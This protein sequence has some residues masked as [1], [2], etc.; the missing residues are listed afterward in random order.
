[1]AENRGRTE[2]S[3]FGV[4]QLRQLP[5]DLRQAVKRDARIQMMYVVIANISGEPGH[6]AVRFQEAGR[7]Q[8]RLFISPAGFVAIRNLGKVVLSVE[9]V[10][11]NG[12]SDEV[13]DRL[14]EQQGLPA[15]EQSDGDTD[16]NVNHQCNQAVEVFASIVDEW[17]QA[18][19]V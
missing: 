6:Q 14:R 19:P 9:E 5:H 18:H 12:A 1:T 2:R 7:F 11:A 13:R 16:Q 17:T 10:G 15:E 3:G 8:S 4:L